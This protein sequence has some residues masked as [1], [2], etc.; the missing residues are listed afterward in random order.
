MS[1]KKRT[2]NADKAGFDDSWLLGMTDI[3][4]IPTYSMRVY[5]NKINSDD[6]ETTIVYE[7]ALEIYEITS[8]YTTK[9][10]IYATN[11]AIREWCDEIATK[12]EQRFEVTHS[13]MPGIIQEIAEG[14]GG[15]QA[16]GTFK[17]LQSN[18]ITLTT[19]FTKRSNRK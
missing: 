3:L 1:K 19:N 17:R 7:D 8:I 4:T 2:T 12:K 6:I 5:T 18:G 16:V 11:Q 13:N 14:S 10:P 9:S 15:G